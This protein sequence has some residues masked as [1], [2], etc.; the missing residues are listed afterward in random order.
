MCAG[1]TCIALEAPAGRA[2]VV[3]LVTG[4]E[5]LLDIGRIG[6]VAIVS[7]RRPVQFNQPRR[8]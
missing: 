3:A 5:V 7:L 1:R 2:F 8:V 4:D 6:G